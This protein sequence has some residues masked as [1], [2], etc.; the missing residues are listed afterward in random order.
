MKAVFLDN[1]NQ[2]EKLLPIVVAYT[3]ATGS[4]LAQNLMEIS[5]SKQRT[6]MLTAIS[7]DQN[8]EY[9][10]YLCCQ[11]IDQRTV[12][13]TQCYS[14]RREALNYLFEPFV[15]QLRVLS[16]GAVEKIIAFCD[17]PLLRVYR[18]F[19]AELSKYLI[20]INLV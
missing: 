10:A 17:P 19:G 7:E 16:G 15:S 5:L 13:V 6:D 1:D 20:E 4:N 14:K 18:R 2:I 3:K 8:G 12:L 9:V 11:F